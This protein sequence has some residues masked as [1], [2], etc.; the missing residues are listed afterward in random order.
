MG[1]AS[2]KNYETIDSNSI[3]KAEFNLS[4]KK[5]KNG[6][7]DNMMTLLKEI[8]EENKKLLTTFDI[9][10][11]G[12]IDISKNTFLD[13]YLINKEEKDKI[14]FKKLYSMNAFYDEKILN[15][16]ND[17]NAKNVENKVKKNLVI[18]KQFKINLVK[19]NNHIESLLKQ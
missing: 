16:Q 12:P 3:P 11:E 2:S 19:Y 17:K 14:I 5:G 13:S 9:L 10:I 6:D 1:T 18:N 7:F 8:N 4:G 15:K